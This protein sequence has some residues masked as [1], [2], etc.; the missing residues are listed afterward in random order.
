[1]ADP[2]GELGKAKAATCGVL[3]T[4]RSRRLN[5]AHAM[6]NASVVFDRLVVAGEGLLSDPLTSCFEH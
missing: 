3:C 4:A 2:D 5:E 1:M 6:W